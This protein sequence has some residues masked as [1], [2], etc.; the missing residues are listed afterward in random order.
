MDRYYYYIIVHDRAG[1][2][3]GGGGGRDCGRVS[4]KR[5]EKRKTKK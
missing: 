1:D 5:N 3:A 4:E 2:A